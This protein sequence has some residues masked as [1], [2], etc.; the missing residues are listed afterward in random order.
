MKLH[1][2]MGGSLSSGQASLAGVA[3]GRLW[4][5]VWVAAGGC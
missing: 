3:G 1:V 5:G 2:D 4:L